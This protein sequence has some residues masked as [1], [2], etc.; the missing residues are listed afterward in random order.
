MPYAALARTLCAELVPL[1]IALAAI[2]SPTG[3]EGDKALFIRRW[4]KA[5][6]GVDAAPDE[7]GNVTVTLK[8]DPG[9]VTQL[10]LAHTDTVFGDVDAITPRVEGNRV[11]APSIGDNSANA[12]ALLLTLREHLKRGVAPAQNRIIAFNVGEEGLGN[13]LG[14]RTLLARHPEV[15]EVIAVDANSDAVI[16]TAVGSLRYRVEVGTCGGHSYSAFGNPSAIHHAANIVSR[17]YT[18]DAPKRPKTTYNVGIIGGGT[19]VNT[20]AAT[21]S[22]LVDL[23]SQDAACLNALKTQALS[24][25]EGERGKGVRVSYECIGERPCGRPIENNPLLARIFDIRRRIGL[26]LKRTAGSTDCNLPL[27][28]GI[29]SICLG[30]YRGHGAHTVEEYIEI[31]SIPLGLRQL[32]MLFFDADKA[33]DDADGREQTKGV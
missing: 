27:S 4:L 16:D 1:S 33:G 25:I 14:T 3:F 32:L 26:P 22:M 6:C 17:L 15:N 12:A 28:L 30:V 13:L 5:H 11:C 2:P 7:V 23:R 10:Y 29:P 19:S 18:M 20:I 21:C 24:I 31:D 9:N 8:G